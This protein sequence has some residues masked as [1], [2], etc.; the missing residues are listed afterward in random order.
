MKKIKDY[1]K[2]FK[3][4]NPKYTEWKLFFLLLVLLALIYVN[5]FSVEISCNTIIALIVFILSVTFHE[6]AHGYVAYKFGDDTA[7][8]DGRITLNPIKHLDFAGMMLPIL[9]LLSGSRFLIGWLKPVPVDFSELKPPKLGLFCVA[10][11]G[12]VVNFILALIALIIL[13][14]GIEVLTPNNVILTVA[15]YT[16]VVNLLLAIFNLIPVTPLDGG[17]ILYSLSGKKVRN[18]YNKIENYG[19]VIVFC[20][21]YSGIF[22]TVFSKILVFVLKLVNVDIMLE[23]I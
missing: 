6:V 13:K 22:S 23:L 16:F 19:V 11:A 18:F 5:L 10:I 4:L 17:R 2:K 7:K 14:I 20:F 9:I 21:V 12:V 1:Y 3:I 15:T 8:K